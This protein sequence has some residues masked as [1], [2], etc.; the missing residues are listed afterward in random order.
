MSADQFQ[1]IA[2]LLSDIARTIAI[3][4][5]AQRMAEATTDDEKIW[6]SQSLGAL[7]GEQRQDPRIG[8]TGG[9]RMF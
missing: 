7:M 5:I 8:E 2:D 1:R 6:L 3:I 9:R 4:A